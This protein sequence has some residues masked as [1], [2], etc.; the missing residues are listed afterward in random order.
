MIMIRVA[1][2]G[3]ISIADVK[4]LCDGLPFKT[5]VVDGIGVPEKAHNS[6]R[7]QYLADLLANSNDYR[8]VNFLP[9]FIQLFGML[10]HPPK[11]CR[12]NYPTNN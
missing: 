10:N 7:R 1:P 5:E 6:E 12:Y 3:N 11:P 2:F 8:A 4:A 9:V